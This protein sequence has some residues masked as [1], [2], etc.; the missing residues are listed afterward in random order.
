MLASLYWAA[1]KLPCDFYHA[2]ITDDVLVDVAAIRD[3]ISSQA[4]HFVPVQDRVYTMIARDGSTVTASKPQKIYCFEKYVEKEEPLRDFQYWRSVSQLD[5]D[6]P[7]WPPYCSEGLYILPVSLAREL[8]DEW[9]ILNASLPPELHDVLVTGILRR[10]LN[11]GDDNI[12]SSA[13]KL[14]PLRRYK[15]LARST[16]RRLASYELDAE[17]QVKITW[18][19]WYEKLRY[20]FHIL[21]NV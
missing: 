15:V 16:S 20:R 12:S 18:K 9:R 13:E 11:R 19:K 6:A 2:S 4:F 17:N 7:F 1:D 3:Y 14:Q 10:K 8:Y 21:T 5:Y